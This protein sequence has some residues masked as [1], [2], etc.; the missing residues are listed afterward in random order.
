MRKLNVF[1]PTRLI[2]SALILILFVLNVSIKSYAQSRPNINSFSAPQ[3][4]TLACAIKAFL[5]LHH[6]DYV[7]KH[8]SPCSDPPDL[9]CGFVGNDDCDCLPGVVRE[10]IHNSTN[11]LPWHRHFIGKLE[12]HLTSIV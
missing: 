7:M 10:I 11:F 6:W 12:E 2:N 8:V 1:S 5:D 3:Q 9:P 4:Q